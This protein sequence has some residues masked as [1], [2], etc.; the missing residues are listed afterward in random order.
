MIDP[1]LTPVGE[2][3]CAALRENFPNHEKIALLVSSPLRRTIHTTLLAF[4]PA[5]AN[6]HCHP[7]VVT[8]PELQ[9]TSDYPCDTGSDV[10]VLR[11][12][13][14]AENLPVDLCLV[15]EGWNTKTPDSKWAPTSE[16]LNRRAAEARRYIRDRV[17]E[18]QRSGE[19]EPEI[20]ITS[21]GGFL[22]YFTEDWEDSKMYNGAFLHYPISKFCLVAGGIGGSFILD[23]DIMPFYLLGYQNRKVDQLLWAVPGTGWENAEYRSFTFTDLHGSSDSALTES[24]PNHNNTHVG[25]YENASL[26]ETVESRSRRGKPGLPHGREVQIELFKAAM[27]GW[28]EQGLQNLELVGKEGHG[29]KGSVKM[30][31]KDGEN[32]DKKNGT[33]AVATT[34]TATSAAIE[35]NGE[36]TAN[37]AVKERRSSVGVAAVAA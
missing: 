23:P 16:A 32:E 1:Q 33:A 17:L 18:L 3:Q 29:M 12:E 10:D 26:R 5:L 28:E 7:K 22:H 20:V 2:A 11:Q 24:T 30:I 14:N 8:L 4:G 9:E 25:E 6:G 35:G 15:K 27:R 21:H 13:M 31:T 36:V 37:V 34:A 19:Q